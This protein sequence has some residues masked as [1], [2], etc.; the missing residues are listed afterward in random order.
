MFITQRS[1]LPHISKKLETVYKYNAVSDSQ[2][3]QELAVDKSDEDAI[4]ANLEQPEV[5]AVLNFAVRYQNMMPVILTGR[6]KL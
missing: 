2:K 6:K 5:L 1:I 3:Q 4:L